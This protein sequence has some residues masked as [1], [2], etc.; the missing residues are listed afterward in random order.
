MKITKIKFLMLIDF[1]MQE[2]SLLNRKG[3]RWPE[4]SKNHQRYGHTSGAPLHHS[5]HISFRE[6]H[7]AQDLFSIT[8]VNKNKRHIQDRKVFGENERKMYDYWPHDHSYH[9]TRHNRR[10]NGQ[11]QVFADQSRAGTSRYFLPS[12][13][14]RETKINAPEQDIILQGSKNTH[15]LEDSFVEKDDE[16]KNE[17]DAPDVRKQDHI[18]ILQRKCQELEENDDVNCTQRHRF[19]SSVLM[20]EAHYNQTVRD[21]LQICTPVEQVEIDGPDDLQVILSI[22]YQQVSITDTNKTPSSV[23]LLFNLEHFATWK[24]EKVIDILQATVNALHSGFSDVMIYSK[25]HQDGADSNDTH[26]TL[27]YDVKY[28]LS[29][30]CNQRSTPCAD[31]ASIILESVLQINEIENTENRNT[32][33]PD[34]KS[35]D[36][37]STQAN[38]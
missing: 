31:F 17:N 24:K 4:L 26:L 33:T 14:G 11:Q 37:A 1:R 21:F 20:I 36:D 32:T 35:V 10:Q 38:A 18:P 34:M 8:G 16:K 7:V 9:K 13:Q 25:F 23:V 28:W 29:D 19:P 12:R 5:S 22:L 3:K 30:L 6:P 27:T 15:Y 2:I